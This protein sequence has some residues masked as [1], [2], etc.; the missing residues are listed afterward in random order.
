LYAIVVTIFYWRKDPLKNTKPKIEV[1]T[2]K[3][4]VDIETAEWEVREEYRRKQEAS[5]QEHTDEFFGRP[6]GEGYAPPFPHKKEG[7]V[8]V[9]IADEYPNADQ[10]YIFEWFVD[11]MPMILTDASDLLLA[12]Q[13]E[14]FSHDEALRAFTAVGIE[15]I[16]L[17]GFHPVKW[18]IYFETNIGEG[19]AFRSLIE[20]EDQW[21]VGAKLYM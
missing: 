7:Y 16:S 8:P 4:F 6:I 1:R 12:N 20:G 3:G 15:K 5:L 17:A 19:E 2:S 18:T 14:Y 11:N 21:M 10:R 9:E 13:S